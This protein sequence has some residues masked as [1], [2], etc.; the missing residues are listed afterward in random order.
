MKHVKILLILAILAGCISKSKI[1]ENN[2]IIIVF[3]D[4]DYYYGYSKVIFSAS[5]IDNREINFFETDSLNLNVIYYAYDL[6]KQT[7]SGSKVQVIDTLQT[8]FSLKKEKLNFDR[9]IKTLND[10]TMA[11]YGDDSQ[12]IIFDNKKALHIRY[13]LDESE[14]TGHNYF[15]LK[16]IKKVSKYK[17]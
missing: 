2:D 4:S 5:Q 14:Y 12:L 16:S 11:Y 6:T 9:D 13:R 7:F 15:L 10:R 8:S 17:T 1:F 3:E